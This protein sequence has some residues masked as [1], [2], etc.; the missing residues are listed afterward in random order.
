MAIL[1]TVALGLTSYPFTNKWHGFDAWNPTLARW[2][3]RACLLGL[4]LFLASGAGRFLLIILVSSLLPYAV[5]WKLAADWRFTEH[6]YP[7]FLIAAFFGVSRVFAGMSPAGLRRLRVERR[8]LLR[9]LLT[10]AL[11]LAVVSAAVWVVMRALPVLT[12]RE[13]LLAREEVTI[14][15]GDRDGAFFGEG[16][17]PPVDTGIVVRVSR[18]PRSV[19]WLPLPRA[20]TYDLTVR[21][22]P[23]PRPT[24]GKTAPMPV[25][26]VAVNGHP[27][28]PLS[29]GWNPERV[30]SYD[31]RLPASMVTA[32]FNRL[33]LAANEGST[34]RLWYLRV[35]PPAALQ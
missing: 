13:S 15:A 5:T 26:A 34:F 17:S 35:R 18:G 27:L 7:L 22:D 3:S 29:L 21:L 2:L 30:G 12:V 33:T 14:K 4:L 25:V 10:S 6:V 1:D 32:G 23:F 28:S 11:V 24:E 31:V 8:K 19:V 9:P 16:W 20:G